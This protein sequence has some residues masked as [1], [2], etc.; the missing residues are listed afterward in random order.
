LD[1]KEQVV[2]NTTLARL[3]PRSYTDL[4]SSSTPL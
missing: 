4:K 3:R 1:K 2:P